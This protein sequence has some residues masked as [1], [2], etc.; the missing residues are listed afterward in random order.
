MQE[1]IYVGL[2]M[3]S[4]RCQ[5]AVINSDGSLVFSRV[6]PTSTPK[7]FSNKRKFWRYCRLG[8]T[9]RESN[10]KRLSHPRLDNAGNGSLKDVSRKVFEAARRTRAGNSDMWDVL[11]KE[12]SEQ[13]YAVAKSS[14][15]KSTDVTMPPNSPAAPRQLQVRIQLRDGDLPYG[16]L[17]DIVLVTINP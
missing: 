16:Q 4:S 13:S 17:S 5:Q 6:V 1:Q 3:G 10:G 7:R 8:I 12:V 11:A 9:R 2:D 14:S 15:G